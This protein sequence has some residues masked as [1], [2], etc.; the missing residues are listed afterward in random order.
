MSQY[1]FEYDYIHEGPDLKCV[2]IKY[3]VSPFIT[4][5]IIASYWKNKRISLI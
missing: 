2:A 3:E 1:Q 5:K 4:N